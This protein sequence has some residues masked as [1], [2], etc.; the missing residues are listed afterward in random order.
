[1]LKI[2]AI[3]DICPLP[4][5]KAKKA[6]KEHSDVLITVDNE[7]ATQNLSKM[8]T[9]LGLQV[10]VEKE[11]A[12]SYQVYLSRTGE[13][14]VVPDDVHSVDTGSYIVVINAKTMGVGDDKLGYALLKGFVYS[15]AEQDL[16]PSYVIFYNGGVHLS[17]EGSEFLDDLNALKGSGVKVLTCGACLDFYGLNGKLAVGEVTNMYRIVELMSKNH[18]VRP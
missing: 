16:L 1:M 2:N 3:G 13:F 14:A 5:I 11:S 18:V 7:I 17:V 10:K 6:L 12:T 4:V 8:A 9:Q 15:L